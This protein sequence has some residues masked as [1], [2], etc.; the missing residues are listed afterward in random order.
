MSSNLM[1]NIT[2][3][4]FANTHSIQIKQGDVSPIL[5]KLGDTQVKSLKELRELEV[6]EEMA[7]VYLTDK[8]MKLSSKIILK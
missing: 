3:V 7:T 1:N 8:I 2:Y 4:D 5:I 6:K